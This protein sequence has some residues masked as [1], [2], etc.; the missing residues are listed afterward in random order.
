MVR[1]DFTTRYFTSLA[2][3]KIH[4]TGGGESPA[5]GVEGTLNWSGPAAEP[6]AVGQR[7]N[8]PH[9]MCDGTVVGYFREAGWLGVLVRT[10]SFSGNYAG[11]LGENLYHFAGLSTVFGTEIAPASGKLPHNGPAKLPRGKFDRRQRFEHIAE[12]LLCIDTVETAADVALV[13]EAV[14]SARINGAEFTELDEKPGRWFGTAYM[15][16]FPWLRRARNA[17]GTQLFRVLGEQG[18]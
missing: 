17:P 1:T 7:V 4:W 13:C 10:D 6:P 16:W 15:D 14:R 9:H 8:V 11:R 5:E 12:C 3:W 18:I 2:P